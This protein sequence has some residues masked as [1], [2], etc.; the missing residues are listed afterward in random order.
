M[1][2]YICLDCGEIFENKTQA[3]I[4][5]IGTKHENY[6]LIGTELKIKVKS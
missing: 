6:G 3:I 1:A 4:H 5:N 2:D